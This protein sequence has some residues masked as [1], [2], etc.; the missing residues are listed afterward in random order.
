MEGN[1]AEGEKIGFFTVRVYGYRVGGGGY[2]DFMSLS[3][4]TPHFY[5]LTALC[6]DVAEDLVSG[7]SLAHIKLVN[8]IDERLHERSDYVSIQTA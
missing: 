6:P 1:F 8:L 2:S 7:F 5:V 3:Y 4:W